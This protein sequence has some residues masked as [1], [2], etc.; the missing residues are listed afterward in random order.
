LAPAASA[1]RRRGS[2][3]SLLTLCGASGAA[4]FSTWLVAFYS[5]WIGSNRRQ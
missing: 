2:L 5:L 1:S 4:L 3:A